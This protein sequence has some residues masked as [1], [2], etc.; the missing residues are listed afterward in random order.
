MS[1]SRPEIVFPFI[2][3]TSVKD[4][5]DF[6][7]SLSNGFP[8]KKHSRANAFSKENF[9]HF[10]DNKDNFTEPPPVVNRL[11]R[12]SFIADVSQ[13]PG[14]AVLEDACCRR[15]P[16]PCR[17]RR[18]STCCRRR[19]PSCP[20]RRKS[21]PRPRKCVKRKVV[22]CIK[23][24]RCPCQRRCC[25]NPGKC[26]NNPYLNYLREQ[27]LNNCIQGNVKTT[28]PQLAQMWKCLPRSVQ[29][30]YRKCKPLRCGRVSKCRKKYCKR[31]RKLP[32]KYVCDRKPRHRHPPSLL[33]RI[34]SFFG[35]S[36]CKKKH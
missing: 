26:T 27:R 22:C 33:K 24:R 20:K 1:Q 14:A 9:Q 7:A 15:R 10:I 6:E 3:S 17:K 36:G 25:H 28:T 13:Y 30:T 8:S 29:C 12:N 23:R 32:C 5:K 35:G 2:E 11:N 31:R 18:I 19:R 21:C 34:K 16:S 4:L